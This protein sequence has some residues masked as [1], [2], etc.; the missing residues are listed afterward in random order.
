MA[1]HFNQSS[2]S[3]ENQKSSLL[4]AENT[5]EKDI[6]KLLIDQQRSTESGGSPTPTQQ[7]TRWPSKIVV[8]TDG[9]VIEVP[10]EPEV[11]WT[12]VEVPEPP[13]IIEVEKQVVIKKPVV[14]EQFNEIKV[15]KVR[16]VEKV[17]ESVSKFEQEI[18][19]YVEVPTAVT[20]VQEVEEVVRRE[21][22]KRIVDKVIVY[23]YDIVEEVEE[24][25]RNRACR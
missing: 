10:D 13:T 19:L 12:D 6:Q 7:Q 17:V 16:E 25:P 24:K 3:V 4:K 11:I 23:E 8:Q 14:R 20:H 22:V 21:V 15:E 9:P 2:L 1:S 18:R 5:F